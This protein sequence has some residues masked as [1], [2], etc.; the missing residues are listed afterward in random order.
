MMCL[1]MVNR[2]KL[3]QRAIQKFDSAHLEDPKKISINGEK[4]SWSLHYHQRMTHWVQHLAPEASEPLL[5]AARSQHI[6]R[7]EIPRENYPMDKS[8]YKRWRK[9]L[10]KFHANEV[11]K[12]L[13]E[14][15]YEQHTVN[16]L[17]ELLQKIRL[18]LDPEVQLLEDA[19]C[20]VFLENEFSEFAQ[21]H[22]KKKLIGIL[23]KTW[24]KMSPKGHQEFGLTLFVY[25]YFVVIPKVFE[26]SHRVLH[27][28]FENK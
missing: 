26:A 25:K 2:D 23:Q 20:L 11:A 28:S 15:G 17:K 19:I 9:T 12:I 14:I 24:I 4:I 27:V 13:L 6:R 22:D 1:S 7:W 8:G 10:A 3:F 16:R 21:K 5:L 18:K